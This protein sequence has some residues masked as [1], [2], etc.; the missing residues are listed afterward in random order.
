[1][2]Y[3]RGE[4]I[5]VD[6]LKDEEVRLIFDTLY[7]DY[8][9][10]VTCWILSCSNKCRISCFIFAASSKVQILS[11]TKCAVIAFSVVLKAQI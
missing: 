9:D 1:M 10:G 6:T 7:K 5:K 8:Y 3:L 4:I 11:I 2:T